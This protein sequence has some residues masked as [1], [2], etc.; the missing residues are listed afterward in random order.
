MLERIENKSGF[1]D[2][3]RPVAVK[4]IKEVILEQKGVFG[5]TDSKG[6][7]S[8]FLSKFT[9]DKDANFIKIKKDREGK[10]DIEMNLILYFGVPISV[11]TKK[12][13]I[14]CRERLKELLDLEPDSIS[15]HIA[16]LKSKKILERNITIKG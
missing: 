16:G 3:E 5:I 10:I 2:I 4:I 15:V 9:F 14:G 12:I 13:I 8:S 1:I 7:R 11:V 6:H